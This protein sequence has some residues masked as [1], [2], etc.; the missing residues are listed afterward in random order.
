VE[1]FAKYAVTTH[2]KDMAVQETPDGFLLAEVPLGNG[3]LDLRSI[4]Q[5]I[6]RARPSCR[7]TLEMITRNP[8]RIPCLSDKYWVTFQDR[9]GRY[10]AE[11]LFSVRA[12]AAKSPLPRVDGLSADKRTQLEE[13]N[14][15]RCLSYARDQLGLV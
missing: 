10:L 8:L 4:V 9:S 7:F 1:S 11:T 12:H 5:T 3:F 13:D 15:R 2:F 6:S 14:V